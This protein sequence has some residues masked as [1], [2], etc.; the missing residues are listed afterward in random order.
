MPPRKFQWKTMQTNSGTDNQRWVVMGVSGSGKTHIG[1]LLSE[2]LSLPFV[3][4]DDEHSTASREKMAAG[5]PLQDADRWPWLLRLQAH[6]R[7]ARGNGSGLVLSCS[8]LKRSYR[9]VL[10]AGDPD[11]RFVHLH[12]SPQLLAQR[13]QQR[14]GHFMPPALLASQLA[15][16][17]PLEEDEGGVTL[18]IAGLPEVIVEDLLAWRRAD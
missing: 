14:Q 17:E 6:L 2:R 15:A 8:A 11:V 4:G 18:D 12:G 1:R 9:D 7:R 10:R 16:L 13:L 5:I 3:E